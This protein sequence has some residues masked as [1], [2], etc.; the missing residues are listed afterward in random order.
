MKAASP[1]LALVATVALL[2][3]ASAQTLLVD[4]GPST[5]TTSSPDVNGNTWNNMTAH[6]ASSS[7]GLVW[8]DNSSS[9][10]TL[11]ITTAFANTG[12]G[13]SPPALTGTGSLGNLNI[14]TALS[15]FFYVNNGSAVV[16]FSGLDS[17]KTYTFSLLGSR[18]ATAVRNTTYSV[19]G[20][21]SGSDSLQTSGTDLG[22][23]GIN[24]NNSSLAVISGIT[25]DGSNSITLTVSSSGLGY[26]N[27]LQ[28]TAVPEPGS[29]LLLLGGAAVLVFTNA[30][31]FRRA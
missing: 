4:F 29:V 16:T 13:A 14:S 3:P 2:T 30:R 20:G 1:L 6:T 11:T 9:G 28:I 26:L 27:A 23:S 7:L 8:T 24:Y 10:I 21:N 5:Y 17:S 22:G 18:D 25:P 15:D 31:R 19:A 12:P